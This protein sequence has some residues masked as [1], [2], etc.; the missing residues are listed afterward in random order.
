MTRKGIYMDCLVVTGEPIWGRTP[1]VK[2][3]LGNSFHA[4]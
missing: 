2:G 3:C 4:P 1:S